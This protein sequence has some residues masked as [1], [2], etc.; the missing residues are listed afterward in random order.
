VRRHAEDFFE[1]LR[2]ERR[3]SP[4]TVRAYQHDLLQFVRFAEEYLA[5][6]PEPVDLSVHTVRGFVASL[7]DK[8]DPA[9][10]ARKLSVVRSFGAFLVRRGLTEL[11]PAA[12]VSTPKRPRV[13]PEVLDVDETFRLIDAAGERG[14]LG[15][16][17]RAIAE[18]LYSSGLRVSELCALDVTDLDLTQC[19]VRV[20]HG[21]GGKERIVPL[22]GAAVDAVQA[23]L[24]VRASLLRPTAETGVQTAAWLNYRGGR[25][26][27][28]SVGR[29]IRR[30][31][32]LG[33][34]R[35]V[36]SPHVLRHCCATHLLDSGADLRAIQE[37]L[38][39]ASLRTTQRYTHV[40]I[41][42]LF[43]SYDRAHP[44]A[45]GKRRS[46]EA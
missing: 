28:R 5:R 25:L 31:S 38:G 41:D 32:T 1:S 39:H 30:L 22:G 6:S 26:T 37:I 15:L 12:L 10:I 20:Q 4:H 8:N 45:R 9:S 29:I 34:T 11:N 16:R 2:H 42:H 21:K 14:V 27:T 19:T 7:F 44:R 33:G 35:A 13:L 40:S 3:V 36:A 46:D 17:D 23:Y 18:V 24:A 43:A